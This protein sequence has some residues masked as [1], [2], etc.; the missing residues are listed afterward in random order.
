MILNRNPVQLLSLPGKRRKPRPAAERGH[1]VRLVSGAM[2]DGQIEQLLKLFG[3]VAVNR[4]NPDTTELVI[5]C[6][7]AQ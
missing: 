3:G 4:R 2:T 5:W 7:G 1:A 6:R